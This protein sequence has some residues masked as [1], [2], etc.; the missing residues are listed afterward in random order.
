M[1]KPARKLAFNP[2]TLAKPLRPYFSHGVVAHGGLVFVSGQVGVNKSG[3]VVSPDVAKQT[4]QTIKN[5]RAVLR[6]VGAD[7]DD[8]VKVTV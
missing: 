6:H 4:E 5:V 8:I 7:L 2:P 1:P 3:R